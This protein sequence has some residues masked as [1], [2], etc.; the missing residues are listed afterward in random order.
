MISTTRIQ[1]RYDHRLRELVRSTGD[2]EH[3]IRR[4]VP[5]S[6]A[7]GWLSSARTQVVTL[8]VVERD[9][10]TLLQE[11][12]VLRR[13]VERLVDLLRLVVVL[14]KV[15]GFSP[16]NAR[17]PDG[18]RKRALLQSIERSRSVLPLRVVL[19]VLKLSPSR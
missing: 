17:I 6:T 5:R 19:G 14:L 13:R 4:G 15:S 18:T 2:I 16:A 1:H 3:A 8:D 10:L 12:L 9:V 7:R 11:V